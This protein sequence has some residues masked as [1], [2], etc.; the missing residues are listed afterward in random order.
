[1]R[2]PWLGCQFEGSVAAGER[3]KMIVRESVCSTVVAQSGYFEEDGCVARSRQTGE[4]WVQGS[5]ELNVGGGRW[6]VD[7]GSCWMLGRFLL[8][9]LLPLCN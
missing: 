1:M 2:D 6:N 8:F 7:G 3:R 5:C 9:L 4:V